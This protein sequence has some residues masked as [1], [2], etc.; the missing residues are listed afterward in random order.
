[1][2][3]VVRRPLVPAFTKMILEQLHNLIF[4]LQKNG[5]ALID[6]GLM[7]AVLVAQLRQPS[8]GT[9]KLVLALI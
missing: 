7:V 8:A 6:F 3:I 9:T 4:C 1:M 2:F 5:P